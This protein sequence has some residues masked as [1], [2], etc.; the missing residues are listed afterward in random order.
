M[1]LMIELSLLY[2]T[3]IPAQITVED[4]GG[5]EEVIT[6]SWTICFKAVHSL[7]HTGRRFPIV[8]QRSRQA[9]GMLC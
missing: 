1:L 4:S 8:Q 7:C 6:S 2:L 5:Q 9:T 3:P